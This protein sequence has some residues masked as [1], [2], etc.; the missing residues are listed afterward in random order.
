MGWPFV[1]TWVI[2]AL[3]YNT[4]DNIAFLIRFY[5]Y[6]YLIC[7]MNSHESTTFIKDAHISFLQ[8]QCLCR[9]L[10]HYLIT[11]D[12]LLSY[13]QTLNVYYWSQS[14]WPCLPYIGLINKVMVIF[15]KAFCLFWTCI[16]RWWFF[17]NFRV[18][19]NYDRNRLRRSPD[20][21]VCSGSDSGY[22]N[23][24]RS[25]QPIAIQRESGRKYKSARSFSGTTHGSKRARREGGRGLWIS[26]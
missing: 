17:L 8:T 10:R 7:W 4:F 24:D 2:N 18:S 20:R 21:R 5:C 13:R 23:W 15:G 12:Q 1:P 26:G 14:I 22:G 6:Y 25:N 19:P 9:D 11:L 16:W 3:F